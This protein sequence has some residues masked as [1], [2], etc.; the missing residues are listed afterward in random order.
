MALVDSATGTSPAQRQPSQ[1]PLDQRWD[2]SRGIVLN[3]K[4]RNGLRD[5]RWSRSDPIAFGET[6]SNRR[7]YADRPG[8]LFGSNNNRQTG[9]MVQQQSQ[10]GPDTSLMNNPSKL[11][12]KDFAAQKQSNEQLREEQERHEATRR[13]GDER[14]RELERELQQMRD[15]ELGLKAKLKEKRKE[16]ENQETRNKKEDSRLKAVAQSLTDH[17]AKIDSIVTEGLR[18]ARLQAQRELDEK[19]ELPE[20]RLRSAEQSLAN[21]ERE[22]HGMEAEMTL[23]RQETTGHSLDRQQQFEK[24]TA[25]AVAAEK[26][27]VEVLALRRANEERS[28]YET[29]HQI[30]GDQRRSLLDFEDQIGPI[31]FLLSHKLE[32]WRIA[33]EDFRISGLSSVLLKKYPVLHRRLVDYFAAG[34]RDTY[35]FI[36]SLKQRRDFLGSIQ[37]SLAFSGHVSR[38]LTRYHRYQDPLTS[39]NTQHLIAEVLNEMPLSKRRKH[40]DI[41]MDEVRK[42]LEKTQSTDLQQS[43][44]LELD[45]LSAERSGIT[46]MLQY[47]YSIGDQEGLRALKLDPDWEKDIFLAFQPDQNM[48]LE[49]SNRWAELERDRRRAG[50]SASS[51][52]N[53]IW[54]D[55]TFIQ[56]NRDARHELYEMERFTRRC[57][58]MEMHLGKPMPKSTEDYDTE[59]DKRIAEGDR[60]LAAKYQEVFGTRQAAASHRTLRMARIASRST[61][62]KTTADK[63]TA[64][65]TADEKSTAASAAVSQRKILGNTRQ[66][67]ARIAE[68]GLRLKNSKSYANEEARRKDEQELKEVRSLNDRAHVQRLEDLRQKEL[69][70][71]S[72]NNARVV[73]LESEIKGYRKRQENPRSLNHLPEKID[74]KRRRVSQKVFRP[75][76]SDP[77]APAHAHHQQESAVTSLNFTPT[78]VKQSTWDPRSLRYRFFH[79]GATEIAHRFEASDDAASHCQLPSAI[80]DEV[81]L[82]QTLAPCNDQ[83]YPHV[84]AEA[85]HKH[86]DQDCTVLH[87]TDPIV[88]ELSQITMDKHPTQRDANGSVYNPSESGSQQSES[89]LST[90]ESESASE[91][92]P[93]ADSV[94]ATTEENELAYQI[95]PEDYRKAALASKNTQAAFWSYKLYKNAEGKTPSIHYCTTLE[96][97]EAQ[98]KQFLDQPVIGFDIEWEIG[99]QPGKA[100]IKNNVSLIQIATEDKIGLFQVALFKGD[101]P[102]ELMAPS[103]RA[104]LESSEVAKAGV[105]ISGDA[106]RLSECLDVRMSGLFELSHLYNVVMY[107]ECTPH[108]VNR[109]LCKMA[110][111]VQ[112][113]LLLPLKKDDVRTSAWS[114]RLRLDQTEYAASDAYAGFRLYHALEARR[115]K[116]DPMPP[117]PAFWE[118]QKPLQLGNGQLV[119]PKKSTPKRK[120]DQV[121]EKGEVEP[122][123][124]CEEYFDAVE[125]METLELDSSQTGGVPLSGVD[126]L[127]PTLPSLESGQDMVVADLDQAADREAT[128][129]AESNKST[130]KSARRQHP[131]PSSEVTQADEWVNNWRA[132]LPA[133]YN[134]KVG[135]ASLRAYNMWHEQ[136]LSCKEV[137]SF[138]RD[139]PLSAQ[140][141]ASYVMQALKEENLPYDAARVME[142]LEIL[143][144]SVHGRY[145]KIANQIS[146]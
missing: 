115:K 129:S 124:E 77:A 45:T 61:A 100:S 22:R 44:Q 94:S 135:H 109:K 134:L 80:A 70:S 102:E 63:G 88:E 24:A 125:S 130:V 33:G 101:K 40:L 19:S 116:M 60:L 137:A 97:T 62:E 65:K 79:S 131:P 17:E 145:Q 81:V 69:R 2:R 55:G 93:E 119:V 52:Q 105:N 47:F 1:R 136:K 126:I 50:K 78:A 138:L 146:P 46:K 21:A 76:P 56:K 123:D 98:A 37:Q 38:R 122:D 11:T 75:S 68:L 34:H 107:S 13:K 120:V 133:E 59:I 106:R 99:A 32:P 36:E 141:V 92:V 67:E 113:I 54:S 31:L 127:Y 118:E 90:M 103:L 41:R 74:R 51:N 91:C 4:V 8:G 7:Y 20:Q 110:D 83:P 23:F 112:N 71:S 104:I 43:L 82:S 30:W 18:T 29:Y 25:K 5:Y 108:K 89:E 142:P 87:D 16:V 53:D 6:P 143:P 86:I 58:L 28:D 39:S 117:R 132:S 3:T 144:K 26:R 96:Q 12:S 9:Q 49:T 14:I 95:P 73:V 48:L 35:D 111:Q 15:K 42:R 121:D 27:E 64:Q 139:P 10:E 140:T 72:V 84:G 114:K 128:T 57:F 66:M 85:S